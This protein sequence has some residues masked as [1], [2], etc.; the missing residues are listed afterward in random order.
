MQRARASSLKRARIDHD[1]ARAQQGAPD[2][3]RILAN[4][5]VASRNAT[6]CGG[7]VFKDRRRFEDLQPSIDETGRWLTS[8]N[9]HTRSDAE[10][11]RIERRGY[12]NAAR[13]AEDAERNQHRRALLLSFL[14]TLSHDDLLLWIDRL[15]LGH[16]T[17]PQ[18][19]AL[20]AS[21]RESSHFADRI[22][23]SR[24]SGR[25]R[26]AEPV[27]GASAPN[28]AWLNAEWRNLSEQ[29]TV[30]ASLRRQHHAA[31]NQKRHGGQKSSQYRDAGIASPI[32]ARVMAG[33]AVRRILRSTR[34]HA[35]GNG[36]A[37]PGTRGAEPASAARDHGAEQARSRVL[38][39]RSGRR[40]RPG[41][42]SQ[43]A[44]PVSR[45]G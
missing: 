21:V 35:R 20:V 12:A 29:L 31:D 40:H 13:R 34:A 16:A 38:H 44:K 1:E 27:P 23:S 39:G 9:T 8:P 36:R 45:A 15:W 14:S 3:R 30:L 41:A 10:R 22:A 11:R 19:D 6:S 28:N 18:L 26:M 37:A 17:E 25:A 5:W 33:R 2:R 43:V 4:G 42:V 7:S 32:G 24:T